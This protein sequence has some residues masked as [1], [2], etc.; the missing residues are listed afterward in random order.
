M[1]LEPDFETTGIYTGRTRI[2]EGVENGV[3]GSNFGLKVDILI[4]IIRGFPQC[5]HKIRGLPSTQFTT[6]EFRSLISKQSKVYTV[7]RAIM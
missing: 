3:L 5:L 6:D 2:F 1:L 7:Y 4:E